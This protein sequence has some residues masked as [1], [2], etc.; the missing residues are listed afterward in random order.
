MLRKS[1]PLRNGTPTP[2][3][4]VPCPFSHCPNSTNAAGAELPFAVHVFLKVLVLWGVGKQATS[5]R[6]QLIGLT[7]RLEQ[8]E[9]PT[10]GHGERISRVEKAHLPVRY[11]NT[12][13][14]L[15]EVR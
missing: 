2:H 5:A 6:N 14:G 13:T 10:A 11:V 7:R 4:N 9:A 12:P 3:S 15:Q 8:A 1:F